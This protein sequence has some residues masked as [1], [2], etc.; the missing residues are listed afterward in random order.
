MINLDKTVQEIYDYFHPTLRDDV[1]DLEKDYLTRVSALLTFC[2]QVELEWEQ[3]R[4]EE[5]AVKTKAYRIMIEEEPGS[6]RPA[7][8]L[9]TSP[10]K[11]LTW[12]NM[13]VSLK[14]PQDSLLL[15]SW[16]LKDFEYLL[17]NKKSD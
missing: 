6:A 5:D 1:E 17:Q 3:C 11:Q 8:L 12:Q 4:G 9:T 2:A 16:D 15:S 13:W 7:I 14:F 10:L